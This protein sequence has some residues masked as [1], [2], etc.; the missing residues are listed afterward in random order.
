MRHDFLSRR[1]RNHAVTSAVL[2]LLAHGVFD[3]LVLSS[4]DTSPFGLPSR[5]K[6]WLESWADLVV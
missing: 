4:D 5:E 2:H 6:R 3:L 1:L